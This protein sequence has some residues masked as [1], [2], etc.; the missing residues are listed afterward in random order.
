MSNFFFSHSL[1]NRQIKQGLIWEKVKW[2]PVNKH[3]VSLATITVNPFPHNPPFQCTED[4]I[5]VKNIVRKGE[6]A[7]NKQ[8]LLFSQCCPPYVALIF[9]FK[10]TLNCHLQF[11][12]IW[13]SLKS[14]CLVMGW[15]RSDNCRSRSDCIKCAAWSLIY[16]VC[17]IDTQQTKGSHKLVSILVYLMSIWFIWCFHPITQSPQEW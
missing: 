17:F 14:C 9:H 2:L 4:Y 12:S 7:C 1:S 6:I 8:F 3:V 16:M 5:A 11:V 10:C 15:S 13:T